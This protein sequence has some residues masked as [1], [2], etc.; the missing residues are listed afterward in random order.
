M[1]LKIRPFQKSFTQDLQRGSK[2]SFCLLSASNTA[3]RYWKRLKGEIFKT[4]NGSGTPISYWLSMKAGHLPFLSSFENLKLK[5]RLNGGWNWSTVHS[6]PYQVRRCR[7]VPS[8]NT[9]FISCRNPLRALFLN[10]F[11]WIPRAR[12]WHHWR[13]WLCSVSTSNSLILN[14]WPPNSHSYFSFVILW[15]QLFSGLCGPCL[16]WGAGLLS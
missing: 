6:L 5:Q 3:R 15:N 2:L 14:F 11:K 7:K 1:A 9:H 13:K 16:D 12:P 4:T 10:C 8:Q